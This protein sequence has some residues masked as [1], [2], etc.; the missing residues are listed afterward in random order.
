[1]KCVSGGCSLLREEW[2]IYNK[3]S[4]TT[5]K[6]R[7]GGII[8]EEN[9]L[10]NTQNMAS[11]EWNSNGR[12]IAILIYKCNILQYSGNLF[13]YLFRSCL[14]QYLRLY[15]VEYTLLVN[16][17]LDRMWKKGA[18]AYLRYF[19]GFFF[20]RKWWETP[21]ISALSTGCFAFNGIWAR[22]VGNKY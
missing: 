3:C 16:N 7:K 5:G 17:D 18:V 1:M 10:Y 14:C 22:T 12:D 15:S 19:I 2:N 6:G 4:T 20:C 11:T 8:C 9:I 13:I 21:D